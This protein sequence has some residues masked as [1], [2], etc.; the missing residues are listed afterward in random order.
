M[1]ENELNDAEP[2]G[3]ERS[4]ARS[5]QINT[6]AAEGPPPADDAPAAKGRRRA[7]RRPAK[8]PGTDAAAPDAPP[9]GPGAASPGPDAAG[10]SAIHFA[11]TVAEAPAAHR[12]S[13]RADQHVAIA[14]TR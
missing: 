9:P 6:A 8:A 4:G 13:A 2:S 7:P 10:P 1:L 11:S 5:P 14:P 3:E 12:A